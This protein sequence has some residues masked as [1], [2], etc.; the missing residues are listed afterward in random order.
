MERHDFKV[1]DPV[2]FRDPAHERSWFLDE[3]EG[4]VVETAQYNPIDTMITARFGRR[5]VHISDHFFERVDG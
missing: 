2:R 3:R 1:G 5:S 4:F